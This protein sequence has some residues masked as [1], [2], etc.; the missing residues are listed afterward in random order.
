M[1]LLLDLFEILGALLAEL[2]DSAEVFGGRLGLGNE[3]GVGLVAGGEVGRQAAEGVTEI[4]A[5]RDAEHGN[6][7]EGVLGDLAAVVDLLF[8]DLV[9]VALLFVRLDLAERVG[10]ELGDQ[11]AI[12]V[13]SHRR[14]LR[15]HGECRRDDEKHAKMGGFPTRSEAVG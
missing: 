13:E 3:G 14:G 5:A 12:D 7:E 10:A 8:A 1:G 6:P 15:E 4:D 11:R 9:A 2:G